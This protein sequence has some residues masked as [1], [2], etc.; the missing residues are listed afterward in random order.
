MIT[1][2]VLTRVFFVKGS[3]YGTA[4][5]IDHEGRQYLVTAKHIIGEGI[6]PNSIEVMHAQQW[7]TVHVELVGSRRD[8]VDIAVLAP[9]F[10]LSPTYD[11]PAT[12]A[13][14]TYGED[15]FF[16]GY[17]YKMWVDAGASMRGRPVPFVKR[18]TLSNLD[19]S[20]DVKLLWVDA[21]SNEGFS[22]GPIL[23]K[24]N[25]DPRFRVI[26]VVS[27]FK[28]EQESVLDDRGEPTGCT[29]SYNTGF[30]VGYGIMHAV[31]LI[32]RNPIGHPV[33]R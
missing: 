15:V 29:V 7:R 31:E 14:I 6:E 27:R 18:G 19:F 12:S 8:E 26:G 17:P 13:N 30:L 11:L 16:V 32:E 3:E 1:S 4:F 22:G 21:I 20:E 25:S 24:S 28:T 23:S 10:Q 33:S 2:N 9:K 5:T